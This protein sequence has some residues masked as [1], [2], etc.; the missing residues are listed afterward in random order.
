MAG[1]GG[2]RATC[3]LWCLLSRVLLSVMY[4]MVENVRVEAEDDLPEWRNSRET[5]R[6]EL[7]EGSFSFTY[8]CLGGERR[9][10]CHPR[11]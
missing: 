10:L 8:S 9:L 4:L 6:T 1:T 3:L 2:G 7:S 5:F 11:L